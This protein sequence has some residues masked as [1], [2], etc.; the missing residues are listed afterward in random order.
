M[1]GTGISG[2]TPIVTNINSTSRIVSITGGTYNVDPT[3]YVSKGYNV[4]ENS[5]GTW[6][7]KA[8]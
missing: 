6:T 7:V 8:D 3:S 4:I 5:D 2:S 1:N